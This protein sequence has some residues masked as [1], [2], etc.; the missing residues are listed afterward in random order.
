MILIHTNAR[1]AREQNGVKLLNIVFCKFCIRTSQSV[2]A[3]TAPEYRSGIM[4]CTL[5][6]FGP[7]AAQHKHPEITCLLLDCKHLCFTNDMGPLYIT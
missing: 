2:G 4:E 7:R 1:M 5:V 6:W 3:I